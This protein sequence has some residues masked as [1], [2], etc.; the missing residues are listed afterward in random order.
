[1]KYQSDDYNIRK[2]SLG[3]RALNDKLRNDI[4]LIINGSGSV[5]VTQIYQNFRLEQ[6]VASHHPCKPARCWHCE[7]NEERKNYLLFNKQGKSN[8]N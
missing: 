2:A 1:M 7:S 3:F 5:K 4:M 6:C 8:F